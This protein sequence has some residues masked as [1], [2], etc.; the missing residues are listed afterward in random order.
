MFQKIE[1]FKCA[2]VNFVNLYKFVVVLK[3]S[4]DIPFYCARGLQDYEA[5]IEAEF[6]CYPALFMFI[7]GN[8]I[9]VSCLSACYHYL[10]MMIVN[11]ASLRK[12]NF[13]KLCYAFSVKLPIRLTLHMIFV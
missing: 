2:Y 9:L 4:H 7:F 1:L 8:D 13:R 3:V 12:L 10:L 6:R 11:N 5:T